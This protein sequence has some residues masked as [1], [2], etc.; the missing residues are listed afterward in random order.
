MTIPA[1]FAEELKIGAGDFILVSIEGHKLIVEKAMFPM[2][3]EEKNKL[4]QSK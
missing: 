3:L 4:R 2:G 1:P